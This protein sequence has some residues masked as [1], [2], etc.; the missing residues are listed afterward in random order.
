MHVEAVRR[1]TGDEQLDPTF[2]RTWPSYDLDAKT[3]ALLAYATKLTEEP[4]RMD[5]ADIDALRRVGWD[6]TAIYQATA[7]TA[8]FNFS[9]R[10]EA[11]SGLPMD[12]IP[13]DAGFPEA[14]RE[15]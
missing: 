11:A 10:L 12:Q 15:V 5:D 2:A 6:E 8:L 4:G 9:G 13:A 14:Q 7:L 1:L 3:R